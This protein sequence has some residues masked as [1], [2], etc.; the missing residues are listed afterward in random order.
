MLRVSDWVADR[1]RPAIL[2]PTERQR[3]GDKINTAFIFAR[4]D[5]VNV[6]G[7]FLAMFQCDGAHC[8]PLTL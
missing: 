1:V 7:I 4:A 6:H 5:L 2:Q 8:V 3:I